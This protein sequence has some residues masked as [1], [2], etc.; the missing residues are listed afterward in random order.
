MCVGQ[1]N[2]EAIKTHVCCVKTSRVRVRKVKCL[3]LIC[4]VLLGLMEA[5]ATV[6]LVGIERQVGAQAAGGGHL[7]VSP[8]TLVLKHLVV[9]ALPLAPHVGRHFF[10]RA[11]VIVTILIR[12]GWDDFLVELFMIVAQVGRVAFARRWS[13]RRMFGA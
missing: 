3:Y 10:Q 1:T 6:V 8:V 9:V 4:H 11:H 13:L 2:I 5:P 7:L 12:V